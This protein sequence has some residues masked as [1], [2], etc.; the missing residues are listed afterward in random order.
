[1]SRPIRPMIGLVG[2]PL[3]VSFVQL[4]PPL[5]VFQMPLP[6]PAAVEAP[7]RAAPLVRRR[8]EDVRIRRIHHEID[9]ARVVVDELRVR[10]GL[11]AVGRL[12]QPAVWIRTEQMSDGRNIGNVRILRMDDECVRCSVLCRDRRARTSCR[13][14]PI[15]TRPLRTT[16]SAGC[17]AHRSRRTRRRGWTEQSQCHRWTT[18]DIRRR[19]A[20]R[21]CRC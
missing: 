19:S 12:V 9:E 14:R 8:V 18:P 2:R 3:P 21:S 15:C 7:R 17:S 6:G 16:N 20:S 1:M 10:P 4:L 13:R 11:A 5:L